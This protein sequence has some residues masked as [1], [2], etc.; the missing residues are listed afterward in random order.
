MAAL[1]NY[2]E[3]SGRT[4]P[5]TPEVKNFIKALIKTRTTRPAGRTKIMP[6]EPFAR[7]FAKW[8][9]NES[10]S[11]LRL[12][13]KALTLLA[14]TCMARP[15]DLAPKVGLKRSQFVFHEKAVSI[16]F[17]GTKNDSDRKGFEVRVESTDNFATDPVS[18]VKAY[19]ERTADRG[20]EN[21]AFLALTPPYKAIGA[22]TVAQI[23]NDVIGEA[24]LSVT[25]FS[26]KAFRPSA[27]TAAVVSGCDPNVARLRGRWKTEP[28]FF[29]HYVYPVDKINVSETIL[30]SNV[31]LDSAH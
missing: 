4:N 5:I 12:R 7:L 21:A 22:Q 18:C 16:H 28:V 30:S 27:A 10:L 9:R 2:F 13:Q 20:K 31:M 8:G 11:T 23:L 14:I 29:N 25:Q 1:T 24:G 19:F 6:L 3:V 26:A 15:S 17:F